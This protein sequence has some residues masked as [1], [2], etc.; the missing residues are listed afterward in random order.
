MR[1]ETE[2]F[3][4]A[5]PINGFDCPEVALFRTIEAETIFC[6]TVGATIHRTGASN[7]AR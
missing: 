7:S 6:T 5:S 3:A 2:P 1:K 4:I